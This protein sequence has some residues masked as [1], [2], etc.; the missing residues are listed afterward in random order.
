MS[1]LHNARLL[2]IRSLL[3]HCAFHTVP[4]LWKLVCI[5][6]IR[7]N[8][9]LFLSFFPRPD[10]NKAAVRTLILN[11]LDLWGVMK[12]DTGVRASDP[13]VQT[14][15]CHHWM[16]SVPH[17]LFN[18]YL[19]LR[20]VCVCVGACVWMQVCVCLCVCTSC[21]CVCEHV[22]VFMVMVVC[23]C[24]CRCCVCVCVGCG[25]LVWM[26]ARVDVDVY[27]CVNGYCYGCTCATR[28]CVSDCLFI[29]MV[30]CVC[31]VCTVCVLSVCVCEACVCVWCLCVW[32][33]HT[34]V[35]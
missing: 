2:F 10:A 17:G 33:V 22:C 8:P 3:M 34:C 23:V 20:C 21:V 35:F 25:W 5:N 30:M 27:V 13:H 14:V 28:V 4:S 16:V 7:P 6:P 11:V 1:S 19:W 24:W 31:M 18:L 9:N 32:C 29:I 12:T 15:F 26:C